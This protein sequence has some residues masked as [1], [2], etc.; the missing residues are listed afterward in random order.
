MFRRYGP[1]YF[2]SQ[3]H[4]NGD[5]TEC[6]DFGAVNFITQ[7]NCVTGTIQTNGRIGAQSKNPPNQCRAFNAP[8]LPDG[9][10]LVSLEEAL[11]CRDVIRDKFSDAGACDASFP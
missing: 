8:T 3:C 5:I 9:D 4:S 1:G 7:I 10:V 11:A 6:L 2:V